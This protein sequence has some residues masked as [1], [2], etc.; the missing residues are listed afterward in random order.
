[1]DNIPQ[2]RFAHV[3]DSR[4][5][6]YNGFTV[7]YTRDNEKIVFSWAKCEKNNI[8][9]KSIGRGYASESL[10]SFV[11]SGDVGAVDPERRVGF[12]TRA[13]F[14]IV[15]QM[16]YPNISDIFG[17][18]LTDKLTPRDYKHAFISSVLIA[19]VRTLT[20]I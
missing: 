2:P 5:P 3:T 12:L 4:N 15:A 18:H 17:D 7:A 9:T 1:M 6:N 20:G 13:E 19:M 8:F 10:G 16:K 11:P 14:N